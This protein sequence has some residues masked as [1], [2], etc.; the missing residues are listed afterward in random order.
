MN[1]HFRMADPLEREIED[2][3]EQL[4]FDLVD[5]ERAGSAA[6][7]ILRLR[8][9]R[10]ASEAGEGVTVEDCRA[11]SRA[12]EA[13][14]DERPDLPARY[15]L[16]VSSPGVERPLVRPGD[17]ERFAGQEVAV[18]GRAELQEGVKR[19]EGVLLGLDWSDTGERVRLRL[20]DGS[21]V[22]IPR[23][24]IKKIHLVFRWGGAGK[25]G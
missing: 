4:G 23:D 17:F 24:R 15:V 2:R 1:R 8:I 9:D 20:S 14:L 16:E 21:E 13:S 25:K 5:L 11:V 7:P 18:F 6:R 12:L 22:H 10:S 19:L 3:V